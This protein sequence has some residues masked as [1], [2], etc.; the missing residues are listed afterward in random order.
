M[1]KKLYLIECHNPECK[2][3]IE[4]KLANPDTLKRFKFYC[5]GCVMVAAQ[6]KLAE[7]LQ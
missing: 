5:P 2:K 3:M 7:D 1:E 6:K 4:V